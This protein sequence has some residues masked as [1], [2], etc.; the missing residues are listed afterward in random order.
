MFTPLNSLTPKITAREPISNE[1][2]DPALLSTKIKGS[3]MEGE[4]V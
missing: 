1:F 3:S 2:I 4:E